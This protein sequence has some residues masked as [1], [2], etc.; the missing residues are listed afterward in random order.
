MYSAGM[1]CMILVTAGRNTRNFVVTT[2]L[3]HVCCGTCLK[4]I[5]FGIANTLLTFGEKYF[6]YD[7]EKDMYDKG[8]TIGGY[9]S[10]WL[11]N[12]VAAYVLD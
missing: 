12:L 10:A 1:H 3:R 4:L 7:G 11:A 6:E 5:Q 9:E 8:L 2:T